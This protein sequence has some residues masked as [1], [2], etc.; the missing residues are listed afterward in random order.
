MA[1]FYT[2]SPKTTTVSFSWPKEITGLERI[3]LSAQGDLQRVLS[4]FFARP[5]VVALVYSHTFTKGLRDALEPLALPNPSAVASASPAAPLVQNR[6]IHLQC[7]GRIVCTATSTVKISS[8]RCARLFLEEGY[9][10]GQLFKK[11]GISPSF[12]LLE[13][14]I[15]GP[16]DTAT[17]EK[18][19]GLGLGEGRLWRRYRLGIPEIECEILE[20]F[21][22]REMF[23]VGEAWLEG[24]VEGQQLATS[25]RPIGPKTTN[26]LNTFLWIAFSCLLVFEVYMY[27]AGAS[28]SSCT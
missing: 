20:V 13:V 21:A 11:V 1:P 14:G 9:G 28:P 16:D 26:K 19:V 4:A 27:R 8:A 7:S 25:S 15:G 18:G 5:I 17:V 23:V 2:F 12:E 22:A 6:Q 3:A 10:I 24:E